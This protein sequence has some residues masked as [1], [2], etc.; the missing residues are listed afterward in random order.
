MALSPS[1]SAIERRL[2]EVTGTPLK[3]ALDSFIYEKKV[4]D[5]LKR[6]GNIA[7]KSPGEMGKLQLTLTI[8][9]FRSNEALPIFF[10]IRLGCALLM[11]A[12]VATPI[13]VRPNL[14]LALGACGL[15]YLLPSMVLKRLAKRRQH[16]MRCGLPD[17]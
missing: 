6:I 3:G 14:I 5:T 17:A 16:R 4:V 13:V 7:P 10:G 15:G 11:F 9:G 1:A 8:A 2:G 12:L